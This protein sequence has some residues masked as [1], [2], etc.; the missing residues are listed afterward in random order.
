[1]PNIDEAFRQTMHSDK[2][3][4]AKGSKI[5][6]E[7]SE[8]L[9]NDGTCNTIIGVLSAGKD[10]CCKIDPTKSAELFSGTGNDLKS[11]QEMEEERR[12]QEEEE[13]R[14]KQK[15]QKERKKL[16]AFKK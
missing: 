2:V 15:K 13:R 16:S 14:K 3:R 12:K 4:I 1:M 8:E 11:Q 6:L 7:N 10:N 9:P 5:S